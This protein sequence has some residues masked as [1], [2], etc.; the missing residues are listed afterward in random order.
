MALI[1]DSHAGHWRG[2]VE[3]LARHEGWEGLSATHAG[4]PV[5]DYSSA[6]Q[7]PKRKSC[8]RWLAAVNDWLR[9]HPEIRT[10]IVS[11]NVSGR[12]LL[13]PGTERFAAAER[14]YARAWKSLPASVRRVFVIRDVPVNAESTFDCIERARARRRPAGIDCAVP[15]G[16]AVEPD[17]AANA[18]RKLHSARVRLIDMT[19]YFCTRRVCP[20]VIG[21][22]LVHKDRDHITDVYARTLGPFLRRH[23][24]RLNRR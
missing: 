2:A 8:R 9:G 17:P 3:Y 16:D 23:V 4:C 20:P 14:E 24:R 13:E 15:R 22:A 6:E 5:R 11:Q 18:A 1:G 10:V 7:S 19:R 12:A 21:G